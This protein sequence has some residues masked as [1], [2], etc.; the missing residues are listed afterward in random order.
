MEANVSQIIRN[1]KFDKFHRKSHFLC[2]TATIHTSIHWFCPL[3]YL[4]TSS[5]WLR[6]IDI[7]ARVENFHSKIFTKIIEIFPEA[8][9]VQKYTEKEKTKKWYREEKPTHTHTQRARF[10]LPISY[11]NQQSVMNV[12]NHYYFYWH[13]HRWLVV[14]VFFIT[15][16]SHKKTLSVKCL[17]DIKQ[18]QVINDG[19]VDD[20]KIGLKDRK[21]TQNYIGMQQH[22]IK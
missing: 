19:N 9:T 12:Y 22:L 14:I 3:Y 13:I 7:K 20:Q 17:T 2:N 21:I 10:S 6:S 4:Y 5:L 15:E 18:K 11:E 8:R 16:S 1:W